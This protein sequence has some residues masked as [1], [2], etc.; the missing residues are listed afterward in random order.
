MENDQLT[1]KRIMVP[2]ISAPPHERTMDQAFETASQF[3][4]NLFLIHTNLAYK[5]VPDQRFMQMMAEDEGANRPPS[6]SHSDFLSSAPVIFHHQLDN[7]PVA[8]AILD[9]AVDKKIDLIVLETHSHRI[10]GKPVFGG[11]AEEIIRSSPCS[12]LT[13]RK[14]ESVAKDVGF[15]KILVAIDF[16]KYSSQQLLAGSDLAGTF[17]A[18]IHCINVIEQRIRPSILPQK[19]EFKARSQHFRQ[20]TEKMLTAMNSLQ[21]ELARPSPSWTNHIRLGHASSQ[22]LEFLESESI[23]LIITSSHGLT[24]NQNFRLGSMVEKLIRRAPCSVLLLKN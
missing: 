4:A 9:F 23:D 15:S 21:E 2:F 14:N 17:G 24:D 7:Q 11:V 3:D 8:P 1:F 13:I 22:I 12:V 16:S 20:T 6:G 18:M 10:L 19:P 5:S